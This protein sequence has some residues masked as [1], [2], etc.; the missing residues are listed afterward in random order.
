MKDEELARMISI[1]AAQS[2]ADVRSVIGDEQIIG[3]ALMSH[4]TA[5]SCWPVVATRRGSEEFS[6]GSRDDF[7]YSPEDWDHFVNDSRFDAAN[8]EIEKLYDA[9]DYEKDPDWH[10][11]FRELV[12]NAS[13]K[14]LEIL[15]EDGFFGPPEERDH[16]FI[17]LCIS[18]SDESELSAPIWA[19]RLNTPGVFRSFMAWHRNWFK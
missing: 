2:L 6:Y 18:D 8:Q 4:D 14:A 15:I 11:R 12:F 1:A 7:L 10:G 16:L 3:Y 13:V 9:G 5:D 17:I 19:E